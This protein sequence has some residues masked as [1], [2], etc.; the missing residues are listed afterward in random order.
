M[1][2]YWS[3]NPL[4]MPFFLQSTPYPCIIQ[5]KQFLHFINNEDFNPEM[6]PNFTRIYGVDLSLNYI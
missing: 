2:Q 3:N 5:I 4:H 6:Y 1:Q